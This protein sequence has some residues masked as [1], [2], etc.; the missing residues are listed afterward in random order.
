MLSKIKDL[1]TKPSTYVLLAIGGI[2][3]LAVPAIA[4]ILK[5]V[6]DKIPGSKSTA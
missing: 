5:P 4:R 3:V 1:L 6:A 2:L